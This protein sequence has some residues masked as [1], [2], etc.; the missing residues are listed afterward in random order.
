MVD[1]IKGR[2]A[3]WATGRGPVGD[4]AAGE[5]DSPIGTALMVLESPDHLTQVL[6][7]DLVTPGTTL[8]VPGQGGSADGPLIVGY[9][10]SLS[11]PGTEFSMSSGTDT[12][13]LQVQSYGI[14]E[15]MSVIGPTL[16]RI[17]DV[18]DFAVFLADADRARLD[19]DF[20]DFLGHPVIQLA[21]LAGLG[22]AVTGDGPRRRLYVGADG[23]LSLS[24]GGCRL[25][26]VGDDWATLQAE[27][28]RVAGADAHP[29]SACLGDVLPEQVRV[30]V[31]A[32]RPWLSR[33]FAALD[34][35]RR[36]RVMGLPVPRVSG[37]GGRLMAGLPDPSDTMQSSDATGTDLPL[38]LW[39]DEEAYLYSAV[40][41]R[42]F[43]L[44][45]PAAELVETLMVCGSVE[46]A[47]SFADRDALRQVTAC[48]GEAGVR[49]TTAEPLAAGASVR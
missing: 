1:G 37:F 40:T 25:G 9:E 45:L 21:D 41:H 31:L 15:Y 28:S 49:L 42:T 36:I 6:D 22:A 20:V 35:I 46:A 27:W 48:F 23:R 14:S 4:T 3:A 19:G 8:F 12:F 26:S 30:P 24:P 10:G 44:A 11:A 38:L 43:R 33:Y 47:A 16:I 39:T 18:A 13:Y 29:G 32:S 5:L 34:G 2:L 17:A 7:S